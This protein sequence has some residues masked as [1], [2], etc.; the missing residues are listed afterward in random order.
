MILSL[1]RCLHVSVL[2]TLA[3][4]YLCVAVI[5]KYYLMDT[6][7]VIITSKHSQGSVSVNLHGST[8]EIIMSVVLCMSVNLCVCVF[9]CGFMGIHVQCRTNNLLWL[10]GRIFFLMFFLSVQH[11]QVAPC[12]SFYIYILSAE[13]EKRKGM[14]VYGFWFSHLSILS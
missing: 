13:E 2:G 5:A 6:H 10:S 4:T 9:Q 8:C 12:S 11:T 14:G 7:T 1:N 3:A